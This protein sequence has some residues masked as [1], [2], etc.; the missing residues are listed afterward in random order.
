MA[1]A[2][3]L[4]L[5][6]LGFFHLP[7]LNFVKSSIAAQYINEVH[8]LVGLGAVPCTVNLTSQLFDTDK[9]P[10]DLKEDKTQWTTNIIFVASS[11][12]LIPNRRA[13]GQ[14]PGQEDLPTHS[15]NMWGLA[16]MTRYNTCHCT[17]QKA[18][19]VSSR[20]VVS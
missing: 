7:M 2:F 10:K 11:R 16:R 18:L 19:P 12:M 3:C 20:S 5:K 1:F 9:I 4:V 15:S 8:C 13:P 14:D 6:K 17:M